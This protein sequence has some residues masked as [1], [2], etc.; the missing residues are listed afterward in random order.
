MIRLI[1]MCIYIY[2][3]M[4]LEEL[5]QRAP[6]WAPVLL[7]WS[8]QAVNLPCRTADDDSGRLPSVPCRSSEELSSSQIS[9]ADDDPL[10]NPSAWSAGIEPRARA[11]RA[12]GTISRQQA[13]IYILIDPWHTLPLPLAYRP[14]R[15]GNTSDVED[16]W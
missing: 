13:Y 12:K 11:V 4:H 14:E 1:A 10:S 8:L 6:P 3:Y 7:P 5:F 16:V 9:P 2:I 15:K